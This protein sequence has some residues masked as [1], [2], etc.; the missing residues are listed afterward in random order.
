M[1]DTYN[2]EVIDEKMKTQSAET[3]RMIAET[4]GPLNTKLAV[5]MTL[6]GIIIGGVVKLVFFP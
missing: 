5:L 2:R 1:T 3:R 4:V 6:N